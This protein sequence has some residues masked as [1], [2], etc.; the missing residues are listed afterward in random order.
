MKGAI[1]V[2]GMGFMCFFLVA[3][4]GA[5][6][7]FAKALSSEAEKE[8]FCLS[9]SALGLSSYTSG[10]DA[11]VGKYTGS[12]GGFFSDDPVMP[13]TDLLSILIEEGYVSSEPVRLN[14]GYFTDAA[15]AHKIESKGQAF[16]D[17]EDG[18]CV[19]SYENIKIVDYVDYEN[20]L[21]EVNFTY[22]IK[23]NDTVDALGIEDA[24]S[25]GMQTEDVEA[26]A[27]FT[28]T[29]KG[30]RYEHARW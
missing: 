17:H 14:L 26:D 20:S 3:C 7:E 25:E 13:D 22:D 18:F 1:H 30:W 16:L 12:G 2:L 27:T 11:Y 5:E 10:G 8:A 19:G 24:L 21:T 9:G 29:N 15:I 23:L 28:K 6:S 4:G